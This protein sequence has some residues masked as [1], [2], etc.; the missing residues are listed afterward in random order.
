MFADAEIFDQNLSTWNVSAVKDM[1]YMFWGAT[2]FNQMVSTWD[3]SNVETMRRQC[4]TGPHPSIKSSQ[5]GTF[6][7]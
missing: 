6:R 5:C 3:V 4:L 2:L 7:Q 1:S